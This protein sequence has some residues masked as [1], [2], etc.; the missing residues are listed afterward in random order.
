MTSNRDL[1]SYQDSDDIAAAFGKLV[2]G[3]PGYRAVIEKKKDPTIC[4]NAECQM[5]L[6]G[7]EKFC[8]HCGTKTNFK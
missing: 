4:P 1:R 6:A 5:S 7:D 3:R 2:S 8:P